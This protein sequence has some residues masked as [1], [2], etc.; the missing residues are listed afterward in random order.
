MPLQIHLDINFDNES[1]QEA[2]KKLQS[3]LDF[4][5]ES[6][7]ELVDDSESEKEEEKEEEEKKEEEK[8]VDYKKNNDGTIECYCGSTLEFKNYNRHKNTSKHKKWE[9]QKKN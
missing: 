4:N 2:I 7:V 5:T 1:I 8:K 6:I 3:L 9:S